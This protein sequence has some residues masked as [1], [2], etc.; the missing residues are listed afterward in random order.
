MKRAAGRWPLL[1]GDEHIGWLPYMWLVYLPAFLVAPAARWRAGELSAGAAAATGVGLV[2]FLASYFRGYWVTGRGLAAVVVVQLFLGAVFF[3]DN[4]GAL[5]FFVYA[6]S[7]AAQLGRRAWW[8]IAGVVGATLLTAVAGGA[9]PSQVAVPVVLSVIIGA[10]NIQQAKVREGNALLLRAQE[11]VE[12]L[13]T[14]AERERIARDLH[15]L[16]GHT[17]SLIVLKSELAAKLAPRDA[18]RAAREMREV[19]QVSREALQQVREAIRGYRATLAD[20]VA[21]SRAILDAAGMRVELAVEVVALERP[22]EE[23][24]ALALREAVTN[25]VR[26]SGAA[27]ARVAVRRV[28]GECVL[29]VEDD[30]RVSHGAEGS[31]LRGMRERVAALG[32]SVAR[33]PGAEG[34]GTRLEVRIPLAGADS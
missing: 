30:G 15:D 24:L 3:A 22:V 4:P 17:L 6:A 16:L 8:A 18:D 5:I 11:Q 26:H 27:S 7:F 32:G 21:Q 29:E 12:H 33:T 23:A 9:R 10:V 34:R 14:V 28:G 2:I 31:G 19:E 13:A 1:P 20:E 25:V